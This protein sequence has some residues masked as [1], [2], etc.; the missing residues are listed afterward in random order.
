MA[1]HRFFAI[2][3]SLFFAFTNSLFA[4][5]IV[6][7]VSPNFGETV[8]GHSV[9]II[10]SGFTGVIAVNFGS[11]PATSFSKVD[12]RHIIA[13][14]PPGSVSTVIV[15][16][17]TESGTSSASSGSYYAYRGSWIVYVV[18]SLN[19]NV[20]PI[21]VDTNIPGPRIPVGSSPMGIA[22]TPDHA[23]AYVTNLSSS[24]V[25]SFHLASGMQE[26]KIKLPTF[27]KYSNYT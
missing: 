7:S 14:A 20:V 3:F 22:I 21:P 8:G 17:I 9:D 11:I 12:D 5:P 19:D 27:P 4:S 6:T 24:N 18:D 25:S 26:S 13:I 1:F 16:V 2:I 23:S 10:G 15:S